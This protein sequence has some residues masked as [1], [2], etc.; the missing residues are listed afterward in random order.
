MKPIILL[1]V[2]LT[3]QGCATAASNPSSTHKPVPAARILALPSVKEPANAATVHVMR[4]AQFVGSAMTTTFTFNGN[5]AAHIQSGEKVTFKVEPG[6]HL[7]GLKFLGNSPI[8]G[9]F[10]PKRFIESAT[11]FV[12]GREYIFRI[13]DNANWEWELKRSSY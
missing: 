4:D 10:R 5:D 12:A 3:I 9:I 13:V 11:H 7:V 1:I 6:E 2:A 8:F